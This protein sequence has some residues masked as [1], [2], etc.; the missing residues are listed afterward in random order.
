MY[1]LSYVAVSTLL[2]GLQDNVRKVFSAQ[3]LQ[4]QNVA[5]EDVRHLLLTDAVAKRERHPGRQPLKSA[6]L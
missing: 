4:W 2:L 1:V 6:S 3:F 5:L